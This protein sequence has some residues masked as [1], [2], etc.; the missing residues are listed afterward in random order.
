MKME[1]YEELEQAVKKGEVKPHDKLFLY[2]DAAIAP[3]LEVFFDRIAEG[4]IWFTDGTCTRLTNVQEWRKENDTERNERIHNMLSKDAYN[5]A[6]MALLILV[7][8]DAGPEEGTGRRHVNTYYYDCIPLEMLGTNLIFP[9]ARFI[10]C[11]LIP[12]N[13]NNYNLVEMFKGMY[14]PYDHSQNPYPPE[15]WQ[16]PGVWQGQI[17]AYKVE[18]GHS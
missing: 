9:C 10:R 12:I 16:E 3:P 15:Y 5:R 13:P 4:Y 1:A 11:Q 2:T 6:Y 7:D 14:Q 18:E 17:G 8:V